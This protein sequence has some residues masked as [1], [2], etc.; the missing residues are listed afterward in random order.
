MLPDIRQPDIDGVPA[1]VRT[2]YLV[3]RAETAC[4]SGL[5][6]CLAP[7]GVTPAQY[8]TMSLLA[9]SQQQSSAALA[10]RT[11]VSPQ[12]MFEIISVLD[13]KGLLVRSENPEHRRI[14]NTSLTPAGRT[15]LKECHLLADQLEATLLL[16]ISPEDLK[17]VRRALD[18]ITEN[19]ADT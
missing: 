15:I 8:T 11:G 18:R 12:S 13:R 2:L 1:N 10:R 16:G 3:K 9:G 5:E 17:V 7:L 6:S 19:S 4:R 14:L